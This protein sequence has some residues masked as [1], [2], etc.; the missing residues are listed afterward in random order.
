MKAH[1]SVETKRKMTSHIQQA[2]LMNSPSTLWT[3]KSF[4]GPQITMFWRKKSANTTR[5][6][7]DSQN[8]STK[9]L[10]PSTRNIS[11]SVACLNLLRYLSRHTV[12]LSVVQFS[13]PFLTDTTPTW[14]NMP[15]QQPQS[16]SRPAGT[17]FLHSWQKRTRSFS[18]SLQRKE[19]LQRSLEKPSTGLSSPVLSS[20]ASSSAT[21]IFR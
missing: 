16:K 20:N 14:A 6:M 18:I 21:V 19:V 3:S 9:W 7:K 10:L 8:Q 17:L 11:Q 2:R 4:Y 1:Q 15:S 5:P 12:L 13:R